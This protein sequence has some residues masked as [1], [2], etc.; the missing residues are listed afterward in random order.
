MSIVKQEL[1]DECKSKITVTFDKEKVNSLVDE[2]ATELGK[3]YTIRGH[4]K[5]K[6]PIESIKLSARK[7]ILDQ[8]K[9]KLVTE[10]YE[11]TLFELNIKPFG[12]PM[13]NELKVSFDNFSAELTIGYM[14][15][16][17]LQQYKDFA[18]DKPADLPQREV[19]AD[20][21]K[22]RLCEQHGGNSPFTEDDFVLN[23]DTCVINYEGTVDGL[24]FE[25]SKAEGI[26]VNVGSNT[27]VAGFEDQ[28]IGMKPEDYREF[29]ISFSE[30]FSVAD[31]AGKVVK[32]KV[33]LLSASR[34]TPATYD[35]DLATTLGLDSLEALDKEVDKQAQ[36]QVDNY[37]FSMVRNLVL[38][39][40]LEAN[41]VAIPMWQVV[42]IAKQVALQHNYDWSTVE[43]DVRAQL[44]VEA[45]NKIKVSYI[46]EKI[47]E[48]EA[49]TVL[50][51]E[52][53]LSILNANVNNFP[54][55]VQKELQKG[56]NFELFQQ[57]FREIQDEHIVRWLVNNTRLVSKPQ[58]ES[59]QVDLVEPQ[60]DQQPVVEGA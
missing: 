7:H 45:Q 30:D 25:N 11:D 60:Q 54:E 4:R 50:S 22:E 14:P 58:E 39:K 17:Q 34:K 13:V 35:E 26:V 23:G 43:D 41:P 48:T 56:T 16:F 2:I 52:E 1:V 20:M 57:I 10:A 5:G 33:S 28:L 3:N 36:A 42:E 55:N 27:S 51:T 59:G 18:V 40:L 38:H 9:Q 46:F 15:D 37:I 8:V 24:A 47:K 44:L 31:L 19:M 6:C 21:L 49:E 29:D 32:F 12:Q 53:M